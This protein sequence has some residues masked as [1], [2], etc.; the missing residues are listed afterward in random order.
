MANSNY[1]DMY[2]ETTCFSPYNNNSD[3]DGKQY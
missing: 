3:I 2:F 1:S